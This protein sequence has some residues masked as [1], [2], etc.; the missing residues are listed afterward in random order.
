MRDTPYARELITANFVFPD[1]SEGR[2]ERLYVRELQQE[3]IRFSWWKDGKMMMRPLDLRED[4]LLGLLKN[5]VRQGVFSE[6]FL[7]DLKRALEE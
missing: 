5:A 1:N 7:T 6:S 2:I 4:E 3:E